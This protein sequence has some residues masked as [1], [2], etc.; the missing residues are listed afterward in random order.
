MPW[1]TPCIS[2]HNL[3][4]YKSLA[5]SHRFRSIS[6]ANTDQVTQL[7]FF[8]MRSTSLVYLAFSLLHG[9][10][11]IASATYSDNYNYYA[12][13]EH[14]YG[15]E[16]VSYI[17]SRSDLEDAPSMDLMTRDKIV[18]AREAGLDLYNDN[19]E[20]VGR[21][22]D[23]SA[24]DEFIKYTEGVLKLIA[25]GCVVVFAV[26][27]LVHMILSTVCCRVYSMTTTD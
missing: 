6:N 20:L 18:T 1:S 8:I 9:Q 19:T 26:D 21:G 5:F 27:Q 3:K 24:L 13:G 11:S 23:G 7:Q 17:Y 22:F 12:R 10:A 4:G 14:L 25:F 16:D 15:S 2:N